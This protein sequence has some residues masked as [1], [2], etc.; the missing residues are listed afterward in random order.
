MRYACQGKKRH[1]LNKLPRSLILINFHFKISQLSA[2]KLQHCQI[3]VLLVSQ[4]VRVNCE[5]PSISPLASS[6]SPRKLSS[7]P[8]ALSASRRTYHGA[9][10]GS[11]DELLV[12]AV[13]V[14]WFRRRHVEPGECDEWSKLATSSGSVIEDSHQD[15]RRHASWW[16]CDGGFNFGIS[17]GGQR[18]TLRGRRYR[19]TAPSADQARGHHHHGADGASQVRRRARRKQQTMNFHRDLPRARDGCFPVS[20]RPG[21]ASACYTAYGCTWDMGDALPSERART[22][23]NYTRL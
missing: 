1:I 7:E 6:V 2:I 10:P 13:A 14:F 23:V 3:A 19:T 4:R 8:I 20:N 15:D 16:N 18:D 17:G 12:I 11:T 22:A 9:V 5:L 21:S